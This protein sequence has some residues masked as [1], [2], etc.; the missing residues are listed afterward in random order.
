[1]AVVQVVLFGREH[2]DHRAGLLTRIRLLLCRHSPPDHQTPD[3]CDND[4]RKQHASSHAILRTELSHC[5][6][7]A[8]CVAVG[9]LRLTSF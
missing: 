1:M 9:P 7:R 4:T 8:S 5:V 6:C 3:R 2:R